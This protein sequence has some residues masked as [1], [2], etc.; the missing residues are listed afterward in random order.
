MVADLLRIAAKPEWIW[1]HVPN[2]ELRNKAVAG[3]LKAMGVKAGVSDILLMSPGGARLH[4]L[5]LKREGEKPN[6]DQKAF[7][8]KVSFMG[9]SSAWCDNFDKAVEIL[10]HWG[11]V[12]L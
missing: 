1:F 10:K 6:D 4:A 5:E 11:A 2:G 8:A 12:K 9:G 7:L 3:R